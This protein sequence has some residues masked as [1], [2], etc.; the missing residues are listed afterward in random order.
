MLRN[1]SANP[2]YQD[3]Q[4]E[5]VTALCP[6]NLSSGFPFQA[7]VTHCKTRSGILQVKYKEKKCSSTT[8]LQLYSRPGFFAGLLGQSVMAPNSSKMLQLPFSY[9]GHLAPSRARPTDNKALQF[10]ATQIL[11]GG[12][13]LNEHICYFPQLRCSS[14]LGARTGLSHQEPLQCLLAGTAL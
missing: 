5:G 9:A 2:R 4:K 7:P 1:L 8:K 10:T 3:K 12:L 6:Q 13:S 11:L 14:S